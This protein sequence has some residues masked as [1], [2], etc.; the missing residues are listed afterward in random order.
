MKYN[1]AVIGCGRIGCG[2]DDDP[3]IKVVRTHAGAYHKHQS[4]TITALCDVDETKL[5]KYG[6]KYG[7]SGLYTDYEKMFRKENLD[8]ISICTLV[9]SHYE[10]VKEAVA[11]GIKGIFLEKPMANNLKNANKINEICLKN[12]V[13]L[14]IDHQRRFIPIYHNV[15][16]FLDK[17]G[18]GEIQGVNVYYGSGIA[19]TGS[20]MF[21]IIHFLFGDFKSISANL[22]ENP[23]NNKNDP[24]VNATIYFK[25]GIPCSINSLD[26]SHYGIFEMDIFGTLGRL[27][28]DMVK[29]MV[30]WFEVSRKKNLVY[31]ELVRKNFPKSSQVKEPILH[32]LGN[33][34]QCVEGKGKSLCSGIDGYKSL[35]MIAASLISAKTHKTISIPLS[36]LE[37]EI[38]S[39]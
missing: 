30:D 27:R 4:T 10:I 11:H 28:F 22:G 38:N 29:H 26:L 7:I 24:N 2:F 15:K 1:A 8:I 13:A 19:N 36:K 9:E 21:D 16:K 39:N 14:L 23:S 33:L 18:L 25:N 20:H 34:I 17:K 6:K 31:K 5:H 12:G 35:E 37:F 3:S 32:G